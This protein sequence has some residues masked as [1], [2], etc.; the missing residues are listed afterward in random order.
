[1]G[2]FLCRCGH[3][4]SE[5]NTDYMP[6]RAHLIPDQDWEEVC[7]GTEAQRREV[8]ERCRAVWQ[9][10]ECGCLHV[11][12]GGTRHV[13]APAE[14]D[15]TPRHL[16]TSV[17]GDAWPGPMAG[18]WQPWQTDRAKGELWWQDADP[19]KSG[20]EDFD[21][22]EDLTRRYHEVFDDRHARGLVRSAFLRID[23]TIVHQ[24]PPA[25]APDHPS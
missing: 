16:L 7:F 25:P 11:S 19:A 20:L 17:F 24:W 15:S 9:C 14:A 3:V 6:T 10:P 22:L 21:S 2:K 8:T 5:L 12:D 13:F 1:M 23:R 4:M 18:T